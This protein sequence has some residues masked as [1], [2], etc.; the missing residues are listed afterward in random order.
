MQSQKWEK[1]KPWGVYNKGLGKVIWNVVHLGSWYRYG[2][3]IHSFILYRLL[4]LG[5]VGLLFENVVLI[6]LLSWVALI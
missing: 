3:V 4:G 2:N 1:T 5:L 6:K